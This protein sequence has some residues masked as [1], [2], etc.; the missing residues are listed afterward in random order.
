MPLP[1]MAAG[2]SDELWGEFPVCPRHFETAA[3]N[4]SV[5]ILVARAS[6]TMNGSAWTERHYLLRQF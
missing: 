4:G 2:W 1:S 6:M 3:V 5:L